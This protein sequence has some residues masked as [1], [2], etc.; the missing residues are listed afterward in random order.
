VVMDSYHLGVQHSLLQNCWTEIEL[1]N[2]VRIVRFRMR[3]TSIV[4]NG[5]STC[6]LAMPTTLGDVKQT[7]Q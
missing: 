3:P 2:L 6:A 1:L 5:H 4:C 7:R